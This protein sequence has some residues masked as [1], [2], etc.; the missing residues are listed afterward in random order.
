MAE[1]E[2]PLKE[3]LEATRAKELLF[4]REATALSQAAA[5]V[6]QAV[7]A[8]R[9]LHVWGEGPL[10]FL[11]RYVAHRFFHAEGGPP[12]RARM[13][14]ADGSPG[15]SALREARAFV[16][17]G[18]VLLVLALE[19]ARGPVA[20]VLDSARAQGASTVAL[21]GYPGDGLA[22]RADAFVIIPTRREPAVA[23][24][25]LAITNVLERLVARR[26]GIE[27]PPLSRHD[28]FESRT[29]SSDESASGSEAVVAELVQP[30][31]RHIS[32]SVELVPIKVEAG[33]SSAPAPPNSIRFRCTACGG[34]ITVE[35]RYAGR[36]GQCPECLH[37]FTIPRA[38]ATPVAAGAHPTA[39]R[40]REAPES[41]A[42][43]RP[44][45][46]FGRAGPAPGPSSSQE[47]RRANRV[48][49]TDGRVAYALDSFPGENQPPLYHALDDLSLTGLSFSVRSKSAPEVKVGDSLF[50][51]LDF[52]AYVDKVRVQG[53]VRRVGVLPDR[54]GIAVGV[55]FSRFLDDAQAKVRRLVENGNLRGVKRR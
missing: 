7:G 42:A 31:A 9:T 18:D 51:H 28:P 34:S 13:L 35:A 40:L 53:D 24:G 33:G 46:S 37:E 19:G 1:A 52:P 2:D 10:A 23:E 44:T 50:L 22:A 27:P 39:G 26:L 15:G 16:E 4:R 17:R 55:R 5:L 48:S 30:G 54:Q 8:A 29:G 45:A 12:L 25:L 36:R 20:E 6:G 11:A 41:T 47:R 49:V 38:D 32:S 3:A 14:A 43:R 21:S